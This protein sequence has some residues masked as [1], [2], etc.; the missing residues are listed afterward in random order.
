[1]NGLTNG[2]NA[3]NIPKSYAYGLISTN[4]DTH[5]G[6][7]PTY[8]PCIELISNNLSNTTHNMYIVFYTEWP[9]IN[10]YYQLSLGIHYSGLKF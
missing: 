10:Q 8:I 1:M 7:N 5:S 2:L 9:I 6:L 4:N 3:K